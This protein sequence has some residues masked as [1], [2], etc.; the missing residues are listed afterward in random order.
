MSWKRSRHVSW[1]GKAMVAVASGMAS[2]VVAPQAFAGTAAVAGAN[3]NAATDPYSMAATDAATGAPA[4]WATGATGRGVDVAVIDTGV[5]PVPGLS[6]AGKVVNGPDLALD[7]ADPTLRDLDENGHGTFMAGLI[8]GDDA[9]TGYRGVAP[10][11]RI[12]NLK[13][14]VADGEVDVSQVIAAIDWVVQNKAAHGLNIRVLSLSYGTNSTQ[15]YAS[16]PLAFAVEQAWKAGIVVVAAA[17]NTGFQQGTGAPGLA[18]PGYDPFIITAGGYDTM[19]TADGADDAVG[20][21]SASSAGCASCK[22]PDLVAVGSHLQGLRVP[23]SYIDLNH[24]VGR[25]GTE[26]FR[27]SGT[28]EATAVTA[29]AAA[30]V[31]SA[32]PDLTPDQVKSLLTATA[33][34]IP[35][36]SRAAQGAGRLDLTAALTA[37]VA[38][39]ASVVQT[40]PPSTG[41]GSLERSRG[42]DHVDLDGTELD[43]ERDVQL[44]PFS[45]AGM[46][47]LEARQ[48]AWSGPTWNRGIYVGELAYEL[49]AWSGLHR[50]EKHQNP[51]QSWTGGSWSG[52]S[53]SGTSWSGTSWSGTSWSGTSWSGTSWSGTSWS[54][55]SW[56]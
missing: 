3:Y 39:A 47:A 56:Q 41:T 28:S 17:G 29:G 46:A 4:W 34:P 25:L 51:G 43:G 11:A 53:W 15:G 6:A 38:P 19:G 52:T 27:G 42:T 33:T 30:L 54:S 37:A 48:A 31:L 40:A 5:S 14:G 22:A 16:D 20:T 18:D 55:A 50:F 24:P 44:N 1:K 35:G 45:S 7:A 9:A 8:A 36:A 21:Y 26:F 23:G 10:G 49:P 13:V 32:R 2:A 12:V